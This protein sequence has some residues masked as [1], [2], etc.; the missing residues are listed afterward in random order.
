MPEV[1]VLDPELS[2][3]GPVE[4]IAV[5]VDIGQTGTRGSKQF[6]GTGLPSGLTIAETPLANDMYLDVSTSELYQYIDNVWTI[7]GKFAPLTYNVNETVTFTSGSADFTYDIN[8]MLGITETTGSFVVNHNIIGT[9]N[10]MASVITQPTLTATDLDFTI[11]A[12]SL[13]GTTWSNLSGDYDVMISI[14]I[15]EDNTSSAS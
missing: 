11:K 1:V 6:V 9:T 10:V 4:E 13:S 15:G 14:S 7:V 5:S 3:Y 12:K 2:V 8:D